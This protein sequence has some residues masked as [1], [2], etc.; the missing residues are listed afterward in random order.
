MSKTVSFFS[1]QP[2]LDY[3]EINNY[4]LPIY[5]SNSTSKWLTFKRPFLAQFITTIY[6]FDVEVPAL[7]SEEARREV[8]NAHEQSVIILKAEGIIK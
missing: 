6:S 4:T 3:S 8:I 5:L 1:N 7:T 2:P